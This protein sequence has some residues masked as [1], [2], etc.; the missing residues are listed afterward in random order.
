MID[1]MFVEET[2]DEFEYKAEMMNRGLERMLSAPFL[3]IQKVKRAR[4][5]KEKRREHPEPVA[6][7]TSYFSHW[8][9]DETK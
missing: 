6:Q 9:K 8:I 5:L 2:V 3:L 1:Q 7:K 4:R